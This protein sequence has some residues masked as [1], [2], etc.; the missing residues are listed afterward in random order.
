MTAKGWQRETAVAMVRLAS[1]GGS[2]GIGRA[3]ALRHAV[4]GGV[5]AG[6][7]GDH[8]RRNLV[9]L[10]ERP[11]VAPVLAVDGGLGLA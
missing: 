2:S 8:A 10:I 7:T 6:A 5:T 1:S 3:A 9:L 11:Q 4:P